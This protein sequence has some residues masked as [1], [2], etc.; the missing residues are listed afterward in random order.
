MSRFDKLQ[1]SRGNVFDIFSSRY[2][3][4]D[5][6]AH[7]NVEVCLEV[8]ADVELLSNFWNR[9]KEPSLDDEHVGWLDFGATLESK[10]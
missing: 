5:S 2:T 8:N 9:Q 10:V 1:V 7:K 6:T 4:E 3:L